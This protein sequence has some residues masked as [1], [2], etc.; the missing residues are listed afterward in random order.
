MSLLTGP[1]VID[2]I[3]WGFA[4]KGVPARGFW[5]PEHIERRF[6][7]G[8]VEVAEHRWRYVGSFGFEA[9]SAVDFATL[10]GVTSKPFPLVVRSAAEGDPVWPETLMTVRRTND[11]EETSELYRRDAATGETLYRATVE[12]ESLVVVGEVPGAI[13]GGFQH[14][15]SDAI[16]VTGYDGPNGEAWPLERV[17]AW[18]DA[19]LAESAWTLDVDGTDYDVPVYEPGPDAL[20]GLVFEPAGTHVYDLDTT[21]TYRLGR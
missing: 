13:A 17:R 12:F 9:L 16:T 4:A 19:T 8:R 5:R 3:A 18:G 7:S 15:G 6:G 1:I 2:G 21:G 10:K 20:V 14:L 11:V